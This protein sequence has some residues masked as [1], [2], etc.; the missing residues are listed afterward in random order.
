MW[1]WK[2]A[3]GKCKNCMSCSNKP[4]LHSHRQRE[5]V[6]RGGASCGTVKREDTSVQSSYGETF[7]SMEGEFVR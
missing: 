1:N 2:P 4:K 3:G 6:N 7:S 5:I